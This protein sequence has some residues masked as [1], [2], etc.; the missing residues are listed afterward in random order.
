MEQSKPICTNIALCIALLAMHSHQKWEG[1]F[2]EIVESC[3]GSLKEIEK[4]LL[5]LKFIAEES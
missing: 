5:V 1:F 3:T 4:A 2:T